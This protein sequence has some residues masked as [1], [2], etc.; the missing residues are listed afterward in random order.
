MYYTGCDT[1][2]VYKDESMKQFGKKGY[3]LVWV[4]GRAESANFEVCFHRLFL[5][6]VSF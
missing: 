2:V 1:M 6:S 4:V 3:K 5:F